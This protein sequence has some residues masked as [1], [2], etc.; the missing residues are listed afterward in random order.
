[1]ANPSLFSGPTFDTSLL[2]E[3]AVVFD[4]NGIIDPGPIS[5]PA[6]LGY[7]V[8]NLDTYLENGLSNAGYGSVVSDISAQFPNATY[9]YGIS[10]AVTDTQGNTTYIIDNGIRGTNDSDVVF[11]V[12]G[13]NIIN[14]RGGDDLVVTSMGNDAVKAGSGNDTV[15]TF[16][17]DD[18]VDAGSGD[19]FVFLG[20]GND[21]ARGG[22]GADHIEGD[23][24]NDC[25]DGNG[26]ADTLL[27]GAGS[28]DLNGGGGRDRLSGG[29]ENDTLTGGR[30]RDTFVFNEGDGEDVITDMEAG[31]DTIELE[32]ALGVSNFA[33]IGQ[34]S[35]QVG[36]NLVLR[37]STGD[38]LVIEDTTLNDL[39][40]GDFDFV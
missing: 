7:T 19:D 11:D 35:Q 29:T 26:G 1:M 37:F 33:D 20:D 15:F 21:N 9:Y 10:S 38:N 24:G 14:T 2:P 22:R 8:Q 39:G 3:H 16:F 31:R 4:A 28:D 13:D 32:M 36:S 17:G 5:N 18:I 34:I 23:A 27:G 30:G 6:A 12:Q 40:A 25:I